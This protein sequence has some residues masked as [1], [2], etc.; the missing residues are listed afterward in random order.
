[1]ANFDHRIFDT[2]TKT[3]KQL[4]LRYGHV[5]ELDTAQLADFMGYSKRATVHANI[6]SGSFPIP[7]YKRGRA[8]VASLKHVAQYQESIERE[9]VDALVKSQGKFDRDRGTQLARAYGEL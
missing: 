5:L 3:E 2:L 7:T 9:A 6:C 4:Y 8:R 1:M